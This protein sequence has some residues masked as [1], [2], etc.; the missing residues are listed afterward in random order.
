M[1]PKRALFR[2]MWS[3]EIESRLKLDHIIQAE[4]MDFGI[5]AESLQI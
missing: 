3:I 1:S 4:S 5:R 2:G